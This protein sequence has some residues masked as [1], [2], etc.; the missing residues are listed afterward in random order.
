[1]TREARS[2]NRPLP[3]ADRQISIQ[4]VKNMNEKLDLIDMGSAAVETRDPTGSTQLDD[5]GFLFD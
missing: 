2:K 1:L 3:V 5:F 4:G